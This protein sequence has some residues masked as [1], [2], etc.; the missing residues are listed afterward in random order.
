MAFHSRTC[1]NIDAC[2]QRGHGCDSTAAAE[3]EDRPADISCDG[4]RA[5]LSLAMKLKIVTIVT[6]RTFVIKLQSSQTYGEL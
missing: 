6:Q 5:L 1:R 4:T 3:K 2:G